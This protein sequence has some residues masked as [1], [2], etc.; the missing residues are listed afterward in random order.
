VRRGDFET[1]ARMIAQLKQ[2]RIS[3]S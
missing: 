1:A 3:T 2:E